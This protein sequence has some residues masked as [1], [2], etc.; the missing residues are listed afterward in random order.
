MGWFYWKICIM[1]ADLNANITNQNQ[2][3][4]PTHAQL[5]IDNVSIQEGWLG[6][7]NH[8]TSAAVYSTIHNYNSLTAS[9]AFNTV[10]KECGKDLTNRDLLPPP[11]TSVQGLGN[12]N[13][14]HLDYLLVVTLLTSI[15]QEHS[16]RTSQS[17]NL[18]L[19]RRQVIIVKKASLNTSREK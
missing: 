15:Q 6:I 16:T 19:N 11:I 9:G 4:L 7:K 10:R 14:P 12:L 1:T 2:V 5:M 13:K 17:I 18:N 8:R 3:N